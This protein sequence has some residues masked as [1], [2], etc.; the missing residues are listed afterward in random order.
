MRWKECQLP[1]NNPSFFSEVYDF[2]NLITNFPFYHKLILSTLKKTTLISLALFLVIAFTAQASGGGG[3][4]GKKDEIQD[5][6]GPKQQDVLPKLDEE[7]QNG[8]R[9][10]TRESEEFVE[11]GDSTQS[12]FR[13]FNFIFYFLY[14]F[15]YENDAEFGAIPP[16]LESN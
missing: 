15:K 1:R 9:Q 5:Q 11:E 14:K 13:K 12:S 7:P 2:L 3:E 4:K 8:G 16:E 10:F 6:Q